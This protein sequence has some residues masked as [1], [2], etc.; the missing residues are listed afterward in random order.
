MKCAR[1]SLPFLDRYIYLKKSEGRTPPQKK[2]FFEKIY[3]FFGRGEDE[4][5]FY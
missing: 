5:F 4:K 1:A 3:I 2:I